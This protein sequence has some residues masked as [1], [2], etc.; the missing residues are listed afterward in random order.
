MSLALVALLLGGLCTSES[1]PPLILTKANPATVS[2]A[3]NTTITLTGSG[4]QHGTPAGWVL[5]CRIG[6]ACPGAG[7][8]CTTFTHQGYTGGA[9]YANATVLNDTH[10][11]CVAPAVFVPGP[12][13]LSVCI[14]Q[15]LPGSA[16]VCNAPSNTTRVTYITP[17]AAVLSRRPY[18]NE[19]QGELL[20]TIH[21]TIAGT[22]LK[23]QASL[24]FASRR[25]DWVVKPNGPS[26]VVLPLDLAELPATI[27]ADLRI[28]VDYGTE[29]NLTIWRRLMRTPLPAAPAEAAA[30]VQ[31]DHSSELQ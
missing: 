20:I 28:D 18:I 19:T 3:V 4:F 14:L 9:L 15:D 1:V 13:L 11:T 2:T 31:V 29:S 7:S 17:V 6:S 5:R 26:T 24:A 12:G 21:P 27:N 10:A 23:V 25:W 16:W 22:E 30:V 8:H